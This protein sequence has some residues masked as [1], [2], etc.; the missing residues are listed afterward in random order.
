MLNW[1]LLRLTSLPRPCVSGNELKLNCIVSVH[2]IFPTHNS[3][4]SSQNATRKMEELGPWMKLFWEVSWQYVTWMVTLINFRWKLGTS[5]AFVV[6]QNLSLGNW[7][8]IA[9]FL[10]NK[11]FIKLTS[12]NFSHNAAS[13]VE[14]SVSKIVQ[15]DSKKLAENMCRGCTCTRFCCFW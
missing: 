1:G 7:N 12:I 9:G 15:M 2:Q 14:R 13:D 6:V 10:F 8:W 3:W 4:S 11:F 5:V